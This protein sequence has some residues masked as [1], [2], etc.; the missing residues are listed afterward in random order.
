MTAPKKFRAACY[1]IEGINSFAV[2]I[3][4]NYL[5][6]FFRDKFGFND[7]ENLELAALLG[8]IYVFAAWQAGKFA[9]RGGNFTALKI[10]FA[11]MAAG[12]AIG[13]QLD[14][15]AGQIAA[16][17]VVNVGMCFTWPVLEALVSEGADAARAVGIYN[18]TWAVNNAVAFFLGGL[19]I[20]KLGYQSMFYVPLGFMLLQF[21]MVF[22][23]EKI[24]P[25]SSGT[26]VSP[27]QPKGVS[28]SMAQPGRDARPADRRDARPTMPA[29]AKDFQR[30]AWLANPFAYLAINTLIAVLPGIAA[31]FQLSPMEAGFMCSLW[32]FA[33]V[34]AFIVL[35]KWAGWH[36]RFRWLVSAYGLLIISFAMILMA[37]SLAAIVIAQLFFGVTVGLMYYSS[38]FYA[39]DA[40]ETK[41][42]HGGIHEAAIG[43]GNFLGPAVGAAAIW[44][45][46]QSAT[47]GAWAVSGLLA[48]GLGGL[49]W[50]RP[51]RVEPE[52]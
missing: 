52:A 45:A 36:Y 18:I 40:S 4:F 37:H 33:R 14:S 10:G 32:C 50:L 12:L 11:V 15:V 24:Q 8:V 17:C 28:P 34:I 9:Q 30:L 20:E 42:E 29:R 22:W 44:F 2:V 21:G 27:V 5:F 38:L 19:L 23:L 7:R 48:A 16:A 51:R 31:K 1:T 41:S 26:G 13:S 39:M 49:L 35:W 47:A 6:F 25:Q 43:V 46:P 3:Y